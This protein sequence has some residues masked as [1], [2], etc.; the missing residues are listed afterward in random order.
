MKIYF[1]II[2]LFTFKLTTANTKNFTIDMFF[3]NDKMDEL[4]FPDGS[5]YS[6]V[7][8]RGTWQ[9]SFGD[10]GTLNCLFNFSSDNNNKNL[11]LIGFCDGKNQSGEKLWLKLERNTEDFDA[12]LGRSSITHG[13]GKY[14]SLVGIKCIYA[15]NIL[16][17]SAFSKHKCK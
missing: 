15:V 9:D 6:N 14:K 11:N 13:T 2:I 12:G 8:N 7:K 1:L 3:I 16:D 17:E 10:F 5:R 4:T